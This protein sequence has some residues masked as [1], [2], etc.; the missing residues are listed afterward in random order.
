MYGISA[1][2]RSSR[3]AE[4]AVA[5]RSVSVAAA[6]TRSVAIETAQSLREILVSLPLRQRTS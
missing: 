5:I 6:A 2:R 3:A 1:A 4:K